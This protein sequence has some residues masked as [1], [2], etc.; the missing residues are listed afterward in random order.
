MDQVSI[1]IISITVKVDW[2]HGENIQYYLEKAR[3]AAYGTPQK[4]DFALQY[5]GIEN[6]QYLGYMVIM[7]LDNQHLDN[8]NNNNCYW[9]YSIDGQEA[10][11]GIDLE[12]PK[13]GAQIE[14]RYNQL[15]S[16]QP[17]NTVT[18][19]KVTFNRK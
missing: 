11:L 15:G 14:F 19:A 18:A 10:L 8:Y 4:F 17:Q 9:E 13:P 1:K 7:M 12:Y 6:G 3:D 16:G 5:Y 2:V